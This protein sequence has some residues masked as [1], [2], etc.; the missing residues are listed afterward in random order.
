MFLKDP[1]VMECLGVLMN[2]DL[3]A[4]GDGMPNTKDDQEMPTPTPTPTATKKAAETKSEPMDTDMNESQK[5]VSCLLVNKP[6]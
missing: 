5:S 3:S 2:F 1:R 4:T 6:I